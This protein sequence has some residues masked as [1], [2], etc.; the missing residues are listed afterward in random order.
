M[1]AP[2][3]VKKNLPKTKKPQENSTETSVSI[4][5]AKKELIHKGPIPPTLPYSKDTQIL[6][7]P[8]LTI[9]LLW[10]KIISNT[11]RIWTKKSKKMSFLS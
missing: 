8:F 6:M 1:Q 4:V 3:N 2:K 10:L 5:L 7:R 11:F 9:L